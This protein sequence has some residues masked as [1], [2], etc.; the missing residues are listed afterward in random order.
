M[1]KAGLLFI[2]MICSFLVTTAAQAQNAAIDYFVGKWEI[3]A[4]GIQGSDVKM[5]LIVEKDSGKL[6][7]KFAPGDDGEM[8]INSISAVVEPIGLRLNFTTPD[9]NYDVDMYLK[10]KDD[11]NVTGDIMNMFDLKGKRLAK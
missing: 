9:G 11:D 10:K 7:G 4:E 1:K 8:K 3:I 6:I 2:G 5:T